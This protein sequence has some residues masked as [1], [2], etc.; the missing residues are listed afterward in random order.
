MATLLITIVILTVL[1][2][3]LAALDRVLAAAVAD[4]ISDRV[5]TANDLQARPSV[6]VLGFPFLT[7][8]A[9][10]DYR[11]VSITLG[12]SVTAGG[13]ELSEL[14]A[15]FTGVHASLGR[16]LWPG[17]SATSEI[18]A[19]R[20]SATALVPF[21]VLSQRLPPG[22]TLSPAGA[23]LKVISTVL[24]VPLLGTLALGVCPA[25]IRITPR[26]TGVPALVGFVI[27]LQALPLQLSVT[28]VSVTEQGLRVSAAGR[29][30]RLA[31]IRDASAS[32]TENPPSSP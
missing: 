17:R 32:A 30:V 7:Q 6:R 2:A 12:S 29:N 3:L 23:D 28:S 11:Q 21:T 1:I 8:F 24:G 9:S 19:E 15:R 20:A 16:L 18:T 13:V 22:L 14:D 5:A 26:I 10:G 25:G 27:P 31:A 4:Q